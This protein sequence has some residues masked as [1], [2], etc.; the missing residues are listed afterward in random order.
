MTGRRRLGGSYRRRR[1]RPV[2]KPLICVAAALREAS[3]A[4]SLR[5]ASAGLDPTLRKFFSDAS[6]RCAGCSRCTGTSVS[7]RRG[8]RLSYLHRAC[9]CRVP[10]PF[11]CGE[12]A[13]HEHHEKDRAARRRSGRSLAVAPAN[14][15][16]GVRPEPRGGEVHPGTPR[17]RTDRNPGCSPQGD[18]RVR[19]EGRLLRDRDGPVRA[20]APSRP[21]SDPFLGVLGHHQRGCREREP[22]VPRRR[23]RRQQGQAGEAPGQEQPPRQTHPPH[24]PHHHGGGGRRQPRDGPPPRGPRG[25]VAR[26]R[27]A[28]LVHPQREDRHGGHG[29]RELPQP[30]P[31]RRL[32]RT[33]T[34]STS[35]SST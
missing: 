13:S 12:G 5:G 24:R 26:R 21:P 30:R 34:P 19:A 6:P 29:G 23:H 28:Q 22:P 27:A 25:L 33:P 32:R 15:R 31:D 16:L 11:G 4:V 18:H 1:D 9:T 7:L 14:I 3:R 17:T 2:V 10:Q 35:T 8:P 20:A